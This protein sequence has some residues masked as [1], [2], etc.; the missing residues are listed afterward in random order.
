MPTHK[1]NCEKCSYRA[2]FSNPLRSYEMPDSSTVSIECTFVWCTACCQVQWGGQ[3]LDFAELDHE[4]R[5][6]RTRE[7]ESRIA[8]RRG[9]SSGPRCLECGSTDITPLVPTISQVVSSPAD[10]SVISLDVIGCRVSR[11]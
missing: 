4:L 7:L 9:H 6:N 11:A 2:A 5:E 3:L 1:A 8:W 10:P